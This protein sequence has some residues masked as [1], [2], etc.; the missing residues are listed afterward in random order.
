MLITSWSEKYIFK[1]NAVEP[2]VTTASLKSHMAEL[3]KMLKKHE[4]Q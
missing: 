2:R 1:L 4:S 3:N